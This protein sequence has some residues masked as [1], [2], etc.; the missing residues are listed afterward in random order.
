MNANSKYGLHSVNGDADAAFAALAKAELV[1]TDCDGTLLYTDKALGQP[2]ID[3][4]RRLK[5]AG[6][7]FTVAS[8]RPG[9]GMRHIVEALDVD[10][11]YASY[12]GGSLVRP[13]TWDLLSSHK[14]PR[15]VVQTSLEALASA[16]VDAWVFIDDAWYLTNQEGTYVPLETRTV[17]YEGVLVTRFDDVDLGEVDKIVGSTADTALL[18][19]VESSVQKQLEGRGHA[20]RSQTYYL[21]ITSLEAN[22]GTAVRELA[23]LANVPLERVAVLGDMGNDVAMFEIAGVSI[24][25]GQASDSVQRRASLVSKS[26]D[27]D[28]FAVGI[29]ALL[30]ARG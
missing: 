27:E 14:L 23:Q 4:V 28:G 26:N 22:K 8:S 20:A 7:R 25:M 12:N 10:M 19:R 9:K 2:A 13:G 17:G 29:D 18:A 30:A 5:E 6:V 1:V 3:A 11:P 16:N 24:A 15:D 21:D